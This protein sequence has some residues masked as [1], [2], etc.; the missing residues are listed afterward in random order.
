MIGKKYAM[1]YVT[2]VEQLWD[3]SAFK[4]FK[5]RL[6]AV[7]QETHG[8]AP[9]FQIQSRAK[10]LPNGEGLGLGVSTI[11]LNPVDDEF[12]LSLVEEIP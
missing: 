1:A 11:S 3:P 10:E 7:L 6:Q 12:Y 8:E 5:K 2:V 4:S 9:N